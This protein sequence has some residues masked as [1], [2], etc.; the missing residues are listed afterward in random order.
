MSISYFMDPYNEGWEACAH[1]LSMDINPYE[2]SE[3]EYR[4]SWLQG[5]TE[6]CE[7]EN[8]IDSDEYDDDDYDSDF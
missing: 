4:T 3:E 6:C 2:N 8:S 7:Y 1:G 5:W